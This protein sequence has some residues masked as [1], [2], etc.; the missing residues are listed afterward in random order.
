MVD[1]KSE[2]TSDSNLN[3]GVHVPA[4]STARSFSSLSVVLVTL[5]LLT[6]GF[7]T[8]YTICELWGTP[9]PMRD[10]LEAVAMYSLFL[11]PFLFVATVGSYLAGKFTSRILA[12]LQQLNRELEEQNKTTRYILDSIGKAQT[13]AE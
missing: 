8:I 10:F 11:F 9:Q 4:S 5:T 13:E 1:D 2:F 6:F 7:G 3:E 12:Q